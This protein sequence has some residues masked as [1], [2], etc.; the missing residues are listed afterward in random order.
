[1]QVSFSSYLLPNGTK[2]P[3]EAQVL[4]DNKTDTY[5]GDADVT[6][7]VALPVGCGWQVDLY[8]GP[9]IADLI[10]NQGHPSAKL[11]DW[12]LNETGEPCEDEEEPTPTPTATPTPKPTST[13]KEEDNASLNIRK[14]NEE[15]RRLPGA[16]FTVEGMEGTFT[17]NARG[18]FCITGLENDSEWLVTEI[19]APEGYVIAAEA[20]QMVEVDDDGDCD[21]PDAVFVNTRPGESPSETPSATP[22]ETP[23]ATPSETPSETPSQTPRE[24]EEGGNPTPKPRGG[25]LPDTALPVTP[26]SPL[27]TMLAALLVALGS[28]G[29]LVNQL[30]VGARNRR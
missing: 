20:S 25:K 18:F 29:V 21:S 3:F 26:T 23:S 16:V 8:L 9:V 30:Q 15:G 2:L 28:A 1:V 14:V 22:S 7:T 19:Q 10:P 11:I 13:P 17:T 6:V 24:D 5:P 27:P 12:S 4:Y